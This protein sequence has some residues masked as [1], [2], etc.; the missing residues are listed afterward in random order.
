MNE[1][2]LKLIYE[3]S[4]NLGLNSPK[5]SFE[6][7]RITAEKGKYA[8]LPLWER[9]AR[10]MADAVVNQEVYIYD[11]DK[12][13]GRVYH[14]NGVKVEGYDSYAYYYK[15]ARE[16]TKEVFPEGEEL[17]E[18]RIM[19]WGSFGHIAWNWNDML[20]LG[21]DGIRKKCQRSLVRNAG[22]QKSVEFLNGVLIML[23]ALD[24][25]NDKH[26]EKLL[27]MGKVE[28]A[29]ICKRVPKYPARNFR[30]AV[31]SFFMQYIIV[32]KEA[33]YG[34]NSPGRLDYYLWPYLER[35]LSNDKITLD[36]AQELVEEMFLRL[37]ERIYNRDTWGET[38]VLGGSYPNGAS[39]VNPLTYIM[40][41][42]YKKYP[43]TTHPSIYLRVPENPSDEYMKVCADYLING[44]NRAQIINDK[45]IVDALVA[46]GVTLTDAYEYYCGGCMEV[47][48]QGKTSDLLYTGA[49]SIIN[50]LEFCLTGGY[51]LVNQCQLTYYK[52]KS[53]LDFNDFESFYSNFI[54]ECKYVAYNYLAHMDRVS[55]TLETEKPEYLLCSM[56]DGCIEKGRN[57]HAGAVKYHDYGL[58]LLGLANTADSLYAVKK[59][60][61]DDKICSASELID[62]LK[63]DFVGYESLRKQLLAIPKY[64]Q[65]NDEVD[66]MMQRLCTDVCNCYSSYKNRFGGNGKPTILTFTWAASTGAKLGATADGRKAGT[67][68]AHGVTPQSA[69]M[70]DG[71]TSAINS[72]GSINYDLFTGGATAMWDLDCSWANEQIAEW[73]IRTYFEKG[74]QFF[75][76][77]VTDVEELI[78]AKAEPEKYPNLI[79]RVGGYSAKFVNLTKDL[80]EDVINRLRHKG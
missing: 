64:G 20:A 21:T 48:V 39:A 36:E 76:G 67:A 27:E 17:S 2:R 22:D 45:T 49:Q 31:Q 38:V 26:V 19:S 4:R 8:H 65:N 11:F 55:E 50:L 57:Q 14:N 77:N 41:D 43:I 12:I 28:E 3:T 61:F 68:I 73:L 37:D 18:F 16:R 72:A 13:I 52:P 42:V 25:W 6:Y 54:G 24:A 78:K 1:E 10:A 62:A 34:G 70:T 23:D 71:I 75:Q 15:D 58:T 74:G 44:Q 32:I 66:A 40:L 46:N 63:A 51:S 79:V 30:E 7:D 35:D 47:G 9:K 29:E 56:I 53:L 60:V 5:Q 33:P 69:F 80:Q 59:A